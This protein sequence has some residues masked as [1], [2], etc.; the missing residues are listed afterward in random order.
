MIGDERLNDY[1]NSLYLPN[2]DYLN[3]LEEQAHRDYVPVIRKDVQNLL[4]YLLSYHK[5][6]RILEV[7]TA[8]GFS[9]ILMAEYN[10]VPC[11]IITIENYAKRI[12]IARSNFKEAGYADNITL[13]EG[14]ANDILKQLD[15][16]F[17]FIFM[18]AAK[19]QYLNFLPEIMRLMNPG[20]VLVTDNALQDGNVKESRYAI[21]RRDRT[22]HGRMR[23]YLYTLTH[24][25]ELST[26]VLPIGDGIT[27]S[28][29]KEETHE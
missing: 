10:P 9:A 14:D 12:P 22:I 7:G 8:I 23:E 11:E 3:N 19:G 15:C 20:A 1:I 28:Y 29:K 4:K 18:D 27:L 6:S 16:G 21:G 26:V 2:T 25:E 5:P 17:D 13:L 24:M